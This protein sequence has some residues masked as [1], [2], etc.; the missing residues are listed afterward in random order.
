MGKTY[1]PTTGQYLDD[2]S[3]IEFDAEDINARDDSG[4]QDENPS[5]EVIDEAQ[6]VIDAINTYNPRFGLDLTLPSRGSALSPNITGESGAV[7][8]AR[9][10]IN[11]GGQDEKP[12]ETGFMKQFW[13]DIGES[14]RSLVTGMGMQAIAGMFGHSDKKKLSDAQSRYYNSKSAETDTQVANQSGVSKMR[15]AKSV[16]KFNQPTIHRPRRYGA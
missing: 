12:Q 13:K 16:P 3:S 7:S 14:G 2:G 15:V 10:L 6:R 1:D 11:S 9:G 5:Q 8:A 4:T